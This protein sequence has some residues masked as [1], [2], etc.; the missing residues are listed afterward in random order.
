VVPI[1]RH[2]AFRLERMA[3]DERRHAAIVDAL[4]FSTNKDKE[5]QLDRLKG[6]G[7]L[8]F[9]LNCRCVLFTEGL[10]FATNG[11]NLSRA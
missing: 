1:L 5:A 9:I 6:L 3:L 2:L 8:R 4:T 11:R 10:L 7:A